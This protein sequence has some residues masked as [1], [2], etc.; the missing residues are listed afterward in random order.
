MVNLRLS[1][2][3]DILPMNPALGC[4]ERVNMVMTR[5]NQRYQLNNDVKIKLFN[6]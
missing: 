4:L 2:C 6:S 5:R 1:Y 3:V